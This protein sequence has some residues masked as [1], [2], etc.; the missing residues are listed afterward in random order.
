MTT[1][2]S[3]ALAAPY[4]DDELSQ[5][6]LFVKSFTVAIQAAGHGNGSG[7]I[8]RPNGLIVT[9]FHVARG[10]RHGVKLSDGTE[11][12]AERI[13]VD[14]KADVAVLRVELAEPF[15]SCAPTRDAGGL[16]AGSVVLALGHPWGVNNAL[17]L[18]VVHGI[19]RRRDG[20]AGW[21]ASDVRLA[22][23]NSGGPLVDTTGRVVGVN[24]AI[25]NGLG[26]AVAANV[27]EDVV[28][29]AEARLAPNKWA[30]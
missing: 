12:E 1:T 20:S 22:P 16:R 15:L 27:V 13:A 18:G 2:R 23:G 10:E 28:R 21:V 3:S 26:V 29:A 30:A 5:L 19:T 24:T 17:S 25:V 4:L 14:R 8:W 7:V 11:V 6:A 9:N